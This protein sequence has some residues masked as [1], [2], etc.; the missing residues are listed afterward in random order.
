[1]NMLS[2]LFSGLT[3]PATPE[4]AVTRRQQLLE[5][6]QRAGLSEEE[7]MA[8]VNRTLPLSSA[9]K[10]R[11]QFLREAQQREQGHHQRQHPLVPTRP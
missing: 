10:K 8:R 4:P 3:V 6:A 9:T 11:Q 1:M 5:E 2:G 7:L